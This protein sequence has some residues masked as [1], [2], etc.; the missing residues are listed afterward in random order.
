MNLT[1]TN[2][3]REKYRREFDMRF[4]SRVMVHG[5]FECWEWLGNK[6]AKGYGLISKDNRMRRAH[7]LSYEQHFG[8][9]PDGKMVA[10]I[11]DNPSCVNPFHL[12]PATAKENT[13]DM[14]HKGRAKFN[15]RLG[16]K[17]K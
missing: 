1:T 13:D 14:V 3:V 9:I 4:W 5:I 16:K 10:H 15:N 8:A 12:A 17:N 11:C 6:S 7:R 2:P